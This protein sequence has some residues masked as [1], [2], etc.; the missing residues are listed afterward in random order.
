[1]QNNSAKYVGQIIYNGIVKNC[2]VNYT[3]FELV[4][5]ANANAGFGGVA[6]INNGYLQNCT[7]TGEITSDTFDIAGVCSVNSGLL[8]KTSTRRTYR[9]RLLIRDGIR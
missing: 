1:M 6:G 4:G 8:S 9:R 2:Q 3:Q 7:V 5:E